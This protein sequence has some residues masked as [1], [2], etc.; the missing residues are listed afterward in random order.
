VA[1][2]I[3]PHHFHMLAS[4]TNIFSCH[5][6]SHIQPRHTS[7]RTTTHRHG[8]TKKDQED[9][10]RSSMKREHR[11]SLAFKATTRFVSRGNFSGNP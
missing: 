9:F 8:L 6:L 7:I 3:F 11:I 2:C 1:G 5:V 10:P 4:P